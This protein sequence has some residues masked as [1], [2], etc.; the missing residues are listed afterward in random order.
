MTHSARQSAIIL[1]AF[2]VAGAVAGLIWHQVWD[3]PTGVV[4][5][6]SWKVTSEDAYRTFFSATG[7][8]VVLSAVFGLALGLATGLL[9]RERE[10]V[11]LATV[12]VASVTAAMVMWR[13]GLALSVPD[14][15]VLARKTADGTMLEGR[16]AVASWSPFLAFPIASL[17]GLLIPFVTVPARER[18]SKPLG[19]EPATR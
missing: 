17:F 6:G 5:Q 10:V 13:T 15:E 18:S 4:A 2:V 8:F 7:W 9:T 16:I 19:T 12:T 11:A 14:P 1:A 3:A